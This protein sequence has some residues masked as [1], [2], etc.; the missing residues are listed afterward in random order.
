MSDPHE[1]KDLSRQELYNLIWSSP[2]MK[3]AADFGVSDVAVHKHCIKR[4]VPRPTRGYWAKL[5]AGR[6]PR[7]K[8]LP[9]TSEEVFENE[10]QRRVPKSLALPEP[11]TQLHPLASEML[12]ALNRTKPDYK[13]LIHL[14]EPPYPE[15]NI[16]KALTKRVAQ[17]FH[18]MLHA[19]E[20]LGIEFKKSQGKY[21]PGNFKMGRDRLFLTIEEVL[22]DTL[23]TNRRV[24]WWQ[25]NDRCTQSGNLAFS[26]TVSH[27][28][29]R[30]EKE[31]V[32]TKGN[33]LE[34]V[35]SEV[36]SAIRLH[37]L[38]MQRKRIQDAI[39]QK[40]WREEYEKRH[41]EWQAEEVIRIQKGKEQ[42]HLNAIQTAISA[43]KQDLIKA[44]EWWS[45]SRGMTDFIEECERRWKSPTGELNSEQAAWL[46]WAGEI[47][48]CMSPF[49]VGYP[50]PSKH[51]A[52]DQSTIPFGGPYPTTQN[53]P[54]T[55]IKI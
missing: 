42:A 17:S 45:R 41:R 23:S 14:K 30:D 7:K 48:T 4:N 53:F 1:L 46:A 31:W 5:A 10:A 8:P 32:E 43:R 6:V 22:I 25:F 35:L 12:L 15:V 24:R 20:P 47:A 38:T 2:A 3:V 28:G 55:S 19:L 29:H 40:K 18:V 34:R 37:F 51:G 27:W 9:P 49:T 36:V 16:S 50:D 33:K 54:Q 13:K 26:T 52:F 44:V 21:N 39:D 11:D